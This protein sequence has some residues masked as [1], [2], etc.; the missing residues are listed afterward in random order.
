MKQAVNKR[1]L[2]LSASDLF[3]ESEIPKKIDKLR[4]LLKYNAEHNISF[5]LGV[6]YETYLSR[7]RTEHLINNWLSNPLPLHWEGE[8]EDAPTK[9]FNIYCGSCKN[10]DHFEEIHY[11]LLESGEIKIVSLPNFF[12]IDNAPCPV[13]FPVGNPP[14]QEN[15]RFLVFMEDE[16]FRPYFNF[17]ALQQA[18]DQGRTIREYFKISCPN[19]SQGGIYCKPERL[20]TVI[21]SLI[22]EGEKKVSIKNLARRISS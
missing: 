13:V 15:G 12:V 17:D 8:D 22:R 11:W 6:D 19:C 2:V 16:Q 4:S 3:D 7:Q 5:S 18:E 14:L 20:Y 1:N 10:I 21:R 9:R